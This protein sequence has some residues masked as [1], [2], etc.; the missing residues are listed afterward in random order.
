M[1]KPDSNLLP[2]KN[3][4]VEGVLWS[5]KSASPVNMARKQSE[6]AVL[7]LCRVL[8]SVMLAHAIKGLLPDGLFRAVELTC[9]TTGATERATPGCRKANVDL[10]NNNRVFDAVE[11]KL[12][13][14]APRILN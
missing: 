2:E 7:R 4:P 1:A 11:D 13:H 5:F 9:P 10:V 3:L 14:I 6:F 8:F 12:C